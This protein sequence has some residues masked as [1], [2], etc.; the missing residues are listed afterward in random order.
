MFSEICNVRSHKHRRLALNLDAR[1]A[2]HLH[3][4]YARNR[5]QLL[6]HGFRKSKIALREALRWRYE[7]VGIQRDGQQA[8]YGIV[9]GTRQTA[10]GD[11]ERQR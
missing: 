3:L 5:P 8:K 10:E 4:A 9:T 6:A 2:H 1:V 7:Q 11:N